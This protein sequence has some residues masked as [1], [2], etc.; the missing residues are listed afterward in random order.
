MEFDYI[1]IGSGAAGAVI[2][3]RL[4]EDPRTRVLL[5]EGGGPGRNPLLHYPM[6][7][8]FTLKGGRYTYRYRTLPVAQ[9]GEREVWTRGR[10]L[11]GS[12]AVNGMMY[13]RGGRAEW[14]ELEALGNPGW[15]WDTVLPAFR[16]MEGHTLGA[17]EWRGGDGPLGVSIAR[18]EAGLDR[19]IIDAGVARHGWAT[20]EDV[21]AMEG[22]RIGFS[23]ATVARGR[24]TSS[25]S[26]FLRPHA[27]RPNLAIAT[28]TRA[29]RLLFD[30]DRVA[31]VLALRGGNREQ[32]DAAREV[33]VAAGTVETPLL[34]ERSG[35]GD[36]SV[37]GEAGIAV[38]VASPKVGT[39][40]KEQRMVPSQFRLGRRAGLTEELNTLP[41]QAWAGAR[42]ILARSGPVSRMPYNVVCHFKSAPELE[43]PD[44]QGILT[45][46]AMELGF[47]DYRLAK[48]SG[49]LFSG[50]PINPR[51]SGS[52]HVS[53]ADLTAP[54]LIESSFL[55]AEEDRAATRPIL[56]RFRELMAAGPLAE[57][58]EAEDF[59]GPEVRTGDEVLAWAAEAGAGIYH[60]V[61]S[62]A[63]G[64]D[65]D[66]VLD[67]R[68]RL[69]GV[70]G[71]R[72]ASAA[73]YPIQ[74]SGSSMA[75]TLALGWIAA[76]LI[77]ADR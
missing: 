68:L 70:E 69:R 59:P 29:E 1:V 4:S 51:S 57:Y 27:G 39:G 38:R 5:I 63:M 67:E 17:S 10:V 20:G 52:I 24:R 8:Y 23:P 55:A 33:V 22:E 72:V 54:P 71:L 45:P 60:A 65:P 46:M 28:G 19:A 26:A 34:L 41:R 37:L 16:E 56:D 73:S 7:F 31:G 14:D 77:A 53:G 76:D 44:V 3:S 6:G 12:T 11:G 74:V 50:Y 47:H 61:G 62:A 43:R 21:N 64:P 49:I 32:F 18:T 2:A 13:M 15:G 40:V 66:D 58:V 9:T 36:P 35:I 30:G 48:H 75:P 42:Y 25:A